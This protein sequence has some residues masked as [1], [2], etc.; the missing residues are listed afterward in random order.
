MRYS[1]LDLIET[2]LAENG[3]E[4]ED[5]TDPL[6]GICQYE[7]IEKVIKDLLEYKYMYLGLTK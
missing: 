7:A 5:Y 4:I 1:Y 2:L 3:C 6:R